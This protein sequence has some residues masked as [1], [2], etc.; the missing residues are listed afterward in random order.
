M[1]HT[2]FT[3]PQKTFESM[4]ADIKSAK[5][6]IYL[7]SFILK[8]GHLTNNF[9]EALK[10][11]SR[12]GI[13]VKIIVDIVGHFY[14]GR[15]DK[16]DLEK[17]GI[18]ILFFNR[19]FYR[20]HRKILI[21]DNTIAYIGGLNITG[22]NARQF[23]LH[24]RLCGLIVKP[25]L[26]SFSR[27][28]KIAGGEDQGI[29]KLIKHTQVFKLREK[30]YKT[31]LWFIENWPIKGK[32]ELK[33]YY[34]E[35][36]KNSKESIE[37]VTPYFVPHAW[38]ISA[39]EKA[40]KRGVSIKLII[41][42]KT[43][44]W[45][46]EMANFLFAHQLKDILSIFV[47]PEG[48]HAKVL[49]IDSC[50]GLVGSNNIDALSFDKNFEASVIFRKKDMVIDLIAILDHWKNIAIPLHKTDFKIKWYHKILMLLVKMI[51]PIL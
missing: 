40:A 41:P 6:S 35:S 33:E 14:S 26:H 28:Y 10:T 50:E 29:L 20:S 31:K 5:K 4:I 37:I 22:K 43:D 17:A 44:F 38:L 8:D 21:L 9:F 12:N 42:E 48:I 2:F 18:E 13:T 15:I 3:T 36:F 1:N 39:I 25:I 47:V 49:L 46:T 30:L 34:L 11:S 32:S 45:L 19:W 23:D 51:H 16:I 7:E 24:M 27:I